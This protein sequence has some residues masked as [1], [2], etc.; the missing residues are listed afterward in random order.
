MG[1][2]REPR[3]A[4]TCNKILTRLHGLWDHLER[5]GVVEANPFSKQLLKAPKS[6]KRAITLDELKSVFAEI[7]PGDV[8][9]ALV[10]LLL[11][12]MR[13]SELMNLRMGDVVVKDGIT[14]LYVRKGKTDAATRYVPCCD[15]VSGIVEEL[16]MR[17]GAKDTGSLFEVKHQLV[18]K[19]LRA[20]LGDDHSVDLHSLR[21]SFITIAEHAGCPVHTIESVVGHKRQGQSVGRYSASASYR[22]MLQVCV[23][24]EQVVKGIIRLE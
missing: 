1:R 14:C 9:D 21:R 6:E 4:A 10:C 22:Q 16:S 17:A 2:P 7:K 3:A 12:G 19:K 24:V 23:S 5:R 15:T 8:R 13:R 20:A 11:T 18:Y